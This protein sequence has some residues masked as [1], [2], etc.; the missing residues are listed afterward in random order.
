MG[1][2]E[3][4][5]I[6]KEINREL[7]IERNR[8][9]L[10][11]WLGLALAALA[12]IVFWSWYRLSHPPAECSVDE[13]CA[14]G[15][16]CGVNTGTCE[17]EEAEQPDNPIPPTLTEVS[18]IQSGAGK[19]DLGL[20]IK[21][22]SPEWGIAALAYG[23]TISASG[24]AA[25]EKS[26][27]IYLLPREERLFA[28]L[29]IPYAASGATAS[30]TVTPVK[31]RRIP[32]YSTHGIE[33][34]QILHSAVLDE[35]AT[36]Q[37]TVI[38]RNEGSYDLQ[39]VVIGVALLD[40]TGKTIGVNQ[41]SIN[42]VRAGSQREVGLKWYDPLLGTPANIRVYVTTNLFDPDNFLLLSS[43]LP[44]TPTGDSDSAAGNNVLGTIPDY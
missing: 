41:T 25:L 29:Q 31:W 33:V 7:F 38:I 2:S 21:N 12:V 1:R 27:T 18:L 14:V 8:S 6:N 30:C 16:V 23:C 36:Y 24:A 4:E 43:P 19:Y 32:G 13:Q 3:L 28:D 42:A 17:K 39:E 10:F 9:R 5:Q 11:V 22:P 15:Y 40:A 44:A 34:A 26:G 20:A 37:A 35:T